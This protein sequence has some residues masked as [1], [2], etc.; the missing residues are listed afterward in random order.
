M[1]RRF[2]EERDGLEALVRELKREQKLLL[3]T[4][5]VAKKRGGQS[6]ASADEALQQ[7]VERIEALEDDLRETRKENAVLSDGL[8]TAQEYCRKL[9]EANERLRSK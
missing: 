2:Q 4:L 6:S 8:A 3:E 7:A 5:E 9:R 1:M